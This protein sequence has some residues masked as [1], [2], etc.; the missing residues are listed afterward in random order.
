MCRSCSA[1]AV[2]C[3]GSPADHTRAQRKTERAAPQ[4]GRSRLG[5]GVSLTKQESQTRVPS[6]SVKSTL[7]LESIAAPHFPQTSAGL[8]CIG[9]V[10]FY[11]T[12]PR[13]CFDLPSCC[14]LA[15]QRRGGI[16]GECVETGVAIAAAVHADTDGAQ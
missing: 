15:G 8:S 9:Y 12:S 14:R 7:R 13:S 4:L 5:R 16:M 3:G 10:P 6:F 11:R 1:G 2:V